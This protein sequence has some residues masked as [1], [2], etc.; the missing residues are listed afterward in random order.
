MKSKE[1]SQIENKTLSLIIPCYNEEDNIELFF[2]ECLKV[3]GEDNNIEYIFI[4]DGSK[5][6]TLN[7]I[8]NLILKYKDY[9]INCLNFSRN[10]GKEAALYA[11]LK[12]SHG[13]FTAIIDA[14]LQQHPKYV[15]KMVDFLKQN[16]SYDE[17]ACYQEKRK[18]NKLISFFKNIFYS[19]INQVSDVNFYKNA[20]DFRVLK[21]NVVDAI[22]SMPEYFRFSKG[23]FSFVGFNTY[24]IPYKVEK[25]KHGKSS[26]NFFSLLKYAI[27]GIIGFS[28][29][30][31][32]ISTFVGVMSFILSIIYLIIIVIQKITVGIPINGYPTIVCLIL[33]FGGLQMIFLGIIGEYI[34]RTYLET[35]KR[36]VYII[37]DKLNY[38]EL[39]GADNEKLVER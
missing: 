19:L 22:L 39:E 25:R 28:V 3:F 8:K 32:K 23:L 37:K 38:K 10:F 4:N 17:V 30:P 24:Y 9:N 27:D 36:P 33:F 34:G 16:D 26:W 29:F 20:S 6:N 13:D 11:G 21:R 7:N 18:E 31:L 35:K 15:K 12:F 2:L 14:D 1:N 5:D